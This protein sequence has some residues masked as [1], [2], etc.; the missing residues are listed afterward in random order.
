MLLRTHSCFIIIILKEAK[1]ADGYW[2]LQPQNY[3]TGAQGLAL[4]AAH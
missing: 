1:R 4:I 2:L 3:D